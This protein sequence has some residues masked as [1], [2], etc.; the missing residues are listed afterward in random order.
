M[1]I[2]ENDVLQEKVDVLLIS[3]E[4]LANDEFVKKYYAYIKWWHVGN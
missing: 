4:R 1:V 3:P 2:I